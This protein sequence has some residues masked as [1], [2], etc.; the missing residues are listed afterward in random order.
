VRSLFSLLDKSLGIRSTAFSVYCSAELVEPLMM[1]SAR[2]RPKRNIRIFMVFR[3]A[4]HKIEDKL[5]LFGQS[6]PATI[7]QR[8]GDFD[9]H[10]VVL[11][12]GV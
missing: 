9:E 1:G 6:I 8:I 4:A 11:L 5:P 12:D 3:N 7:Q 2:D 10:I